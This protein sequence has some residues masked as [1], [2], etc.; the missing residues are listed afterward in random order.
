MEFKQSAIFSIFQYSIIPIFHYS[1][2][3]LFHYSIFFLKDGKF[4]FHSS[5]FSL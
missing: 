4:S 1:I 3:P 5:S 2:I